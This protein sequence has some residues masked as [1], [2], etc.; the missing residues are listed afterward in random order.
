MSGPVSSA[1][2]TKPEHKLY[3]VVDRYVAEMDRGKSWGIRAKK[4]RLDCFDYL[5]ELLGREFN[6]TSLDVTEAGFVKDA[7]MR[8]PKNRQK[9]MVLPITT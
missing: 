8:T 6:F 2:V 1:K 3:R 5:M 7:L 4:E 9:M